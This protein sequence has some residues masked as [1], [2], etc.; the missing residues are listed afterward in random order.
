[1]R[2][3]RE[4]SRDVLWRYTIDVRTAGGVRGG[5]VRIITGGG[6]RMD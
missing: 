6:K 4:R 2:E 3:V 1:M 5:R